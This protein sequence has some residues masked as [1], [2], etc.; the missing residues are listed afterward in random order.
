[1][2]YVIVGDFHGASL[3]ELRRYLEDI[4]PDTIICLGDFGS[5]ATVHQFIPIEREFRRKGK[6]SIKVPGDEDYRI[7]TNQKNSKIYNEWMNDKIAKEYLDNLVTPNGYRT[8]IFI[9]KER[10]KTRY[11]AVIMHGAYRGDLSDLPDCSGDQCLFNLFG[12]LKTEEDYQKNFRVMERRGYKLMIR[13]HDH[14]PT[15]V[16]QNSQG[17]EI[18]EPKNGSVYPLSRDKTHLI[19]PGPF[20]DG[21][22]SVIE[23]RINGEKDPVVFFIEL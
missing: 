2:R 18:Y 22:I 20:Y 8:G 11:P 16:C 21:W 14:S 6:E 12:R 1:M 10:F 3:K 13:G 19:N 7:F 5:R 9:D 17:I 15:Y 23:T 4:N